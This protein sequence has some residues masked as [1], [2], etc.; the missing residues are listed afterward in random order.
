MV[1]RNCCP[2]LDRRG[3]EGEVM[4]KALGKGTGEEGSMWRN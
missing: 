3:A 4:G 2:S 1:A